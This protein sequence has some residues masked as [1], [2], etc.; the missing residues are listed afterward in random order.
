MYHDL[1][2]IM[3]L[4]LQ[5]PKSSR[6]IISMEKSCD[7]SFGSIHKQCTILRELYK[8]KDLSH[9]RPIKSEGLLIV[10]LPPHT[11]SSPPPSNWSCAPSLSPLHFPT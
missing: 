10:A 7:L 3:Q 6:L 8:N 11:T 2:D 9:K 1:E 4:G 5:D